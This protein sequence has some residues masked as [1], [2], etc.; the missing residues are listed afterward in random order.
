MCFKYIEK[1]F[2]V[3]YYNLTMWFVGVCFFSVHTEER[4]EP[5]EGLSYRQQESHLC[6]QMKLATVSQGKES[7]AAAGWLQE[8]PATCS[9][10]QLCPGQNLELKCVAEKVQS[11]RN[12]LN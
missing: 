3:Q 2:I 1:L 7:S 10:A 8:E 4:E 6:Q 12:E 11:R 9:T 5:S